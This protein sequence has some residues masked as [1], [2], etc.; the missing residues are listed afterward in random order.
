MSPSNSF[1]ECFQLLVAGK[2]N[3]RFHK[4]PGSFRPFLIS[5]VLLEICGV[6]ANGLTC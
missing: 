3:E 6:P 2:G 4:T 5:Q 1:F